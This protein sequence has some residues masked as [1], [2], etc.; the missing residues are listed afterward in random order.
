MR[1]QALN[2]ALAVAPPGNLIVC[3]WNVIVSVCMDEK[4]RGREDGIGLTTKG[5]HMGSERSSIALHQSCARG[6]REYPAVASFLI[7]FTA[8]CGKNQ[9]LS[10]LAS[11]SKEIGLG[12]GMIL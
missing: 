8:V 6:C 1:F 2:E 5:H 11:D 10:E 4:S 7:F 3:T 9:G 12:Q